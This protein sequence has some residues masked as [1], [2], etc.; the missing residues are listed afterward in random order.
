MKTLSSDCSLQNKATVAFLGLTTFKHKKY[1]RKLSTVDKLSTVCNKQHCTA[2][3]S[4]E[5]Q[6]NNV[7]YYG[8]TI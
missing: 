4:S 5:I 2:V 1:F 7:S 3:I 6:R 8:H